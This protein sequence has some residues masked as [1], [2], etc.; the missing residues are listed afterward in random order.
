MSCLQC[1]KMSLWCCNLSYHTQSVSYHLCRD[2]FCRPCVRNRKQPCLCYVHGFNSYTTET[3]VLRH[4]IRSTSILPVRTHPRARI[5]TLTAAHSC[6]C[7][8]CHPVWPAECPPHPLW[9]RW[10]SQ[11]VS[12]WMWRSHWVARRRMLP[13]PLLS[14]CWLHC[15]LSPPVSC[16]ACH[17]AWATDTHQTLV[18]LWH[19]HDQWCTWTLFL[20][21]WSLDLVKCMKLFNFRTWGHADL[22]WFMWTGAQ[23]YVL[24]VSGR[25]MRKADPA[26]EL[27]HTE[28]KWCSN[29]IVAVLMIWKWAHENSK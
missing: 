29:C 21:G 27:L 26:L 5:N 3:K 11:R 2:H 28:P 24:C 23:H 19:M 1:M 17:H 13:L 15:W 6:L 10:W 22:E 4:I 14:L 20:T 12:C 25:K 8:S 7:K 16:T 9:T 18:N